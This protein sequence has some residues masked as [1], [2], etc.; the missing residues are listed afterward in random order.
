MNTATAECHVAGKKRAAD[1]RHPSSQKRNIHFFLEAVKSHTAPR[2][3]SIT[4]DR[5][6]AMETE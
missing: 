1:P 5:I 2:T 3:G 4:A 6:V